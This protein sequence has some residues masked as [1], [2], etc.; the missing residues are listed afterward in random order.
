M[1]YDDGHSISYEGLEIAAGPRFQ[2][3]S[4]VISMYWQEISTSGEYAPLTPVY[5][6]YQLILFCPKLSTRMQEKFCLCSIGVGMT[7]SPWF[8]WLHTLVR[9]MRLT[10]MR[11]IE[12]VAL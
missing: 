10:A 2:G 9:P 4:D 1:E 8:L 5:T 6:C 11:A 12:S 3:L 7:A